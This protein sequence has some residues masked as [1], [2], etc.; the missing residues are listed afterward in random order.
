MVARPLP[1]AAALHH[2][3]RDADTLWYRRR[4]LTRLS[5]RRLRI[6]AAMR[7]AV[8]DRQLAHRAAPEERS[9][10]MKSFICQKCLRLWAEE[11]VVHT[12]S[13]PY[14]GGGLSAR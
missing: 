3:D 4:L 9:E 2:P 8:P 12:P 5:R 6:S 11:R 7:A 10:A 14:C 13:C 1:G